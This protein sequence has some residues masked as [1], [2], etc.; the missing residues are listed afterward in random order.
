VAET[1]KTTLIR[2][3]LVMIVVAMMDV[4]KNG[5]K[6]R[7]GVSY[8][9]VDGMDFQ[10]REAAISKGRKGL[11]LLSVYSIAIS[12]DDLVVLFAKSGAA[13]NLSIQ[14]RNDIRQAYRAEIE[15]RGE[16]P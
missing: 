15:R 8:A 2:D 4:A 6:L 7:A 11:G 1:L 9:D 12:D 14:E 10:C 13:G 16:K 3:D 5:E